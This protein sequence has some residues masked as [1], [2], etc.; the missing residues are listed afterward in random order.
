[1]GPSYCTKLVPDRSDYALE[2]LTGINLL[3]ANS[4]HSKNDLGVAID[5]KSG[6]PKSSTI[7]PETQKAGL[8]WSLAPE[9]AD[10]K[11]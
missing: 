1:V 3:A 7:L 6:S 5:T 9:W 8:N 10:S 4:A 11:G 2:L